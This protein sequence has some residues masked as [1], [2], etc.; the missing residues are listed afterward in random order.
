MKINL[1]DPRTCWKI[2]KYS[3]LVGAG[4]IS[5]IGDLAESKS[6]AIL[7]KEEAKDIVDSLTADAIKDQMNGVVKEEVSKQ[8]MEVVKEMAKNK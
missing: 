8:I 3:A 7:V 1:K 5:I 4:I 2:V 6:N